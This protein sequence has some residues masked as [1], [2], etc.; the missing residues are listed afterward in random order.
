MSQGTPG[1]DWDV[2]IDDGGGHVAL[3]CVTNTLNVEFDADDTGEQGEPGESNTLTVQRCGL[4]FEIV[5]PAAA[6][7]GG[8]QD[9]VDA[10]FNKTELEV[11]CVPAGSTAGYNKVTFNAR[12]HNLSITPNG[13]AGTVRATGTLRNSDG[14]VAVW[15]TV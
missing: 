12:C 10:F 6:L 15:G 2:T 14:Q 8:K 13:Q 4:D 9:L 7:T 5:W 11:I 3:N 1:A